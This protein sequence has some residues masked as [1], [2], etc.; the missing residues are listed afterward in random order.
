VRLRA[1]QRNLSSIQHAMS[2]EIQKF[3]N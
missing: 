3:K 1:W 2:H